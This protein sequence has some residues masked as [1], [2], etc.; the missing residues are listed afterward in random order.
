MQQKDKCKAEIE[1]TQLEKK[2]CMDCI[3]EM[4][5]RHNNA[6]LD[7]LQQFFH[8]G[9]R[10]INP[11]DF[12][13]KVHL[14]DNFFNRVVQNRYSSLIDSSNLRLSIGLAIEWE[15]IVKNHITYRLPLP[16]SKAEEEAISELAKKKEEEL[17][18][19][20][21]KHF[22]KDMQLAFELKEQGKDL[23]KIARYLKSRNN[24]EE[25]FKQ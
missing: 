3:D 4:R 17:K 13:K 1:L 6:A 10:G 19:K 25:N 21:I 24:K 16:K 2:A 14:G 23:D 7:F 20:F 18:Q 12:S 5:L 8:Y 15:N 11:N 22:G 9:D